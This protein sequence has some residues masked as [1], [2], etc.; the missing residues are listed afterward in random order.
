MGDLG[1]LTALVVSGYGNIDEL[2]TTGPNQ[3][4]QLRDGAVTTYEFDPEEYGFRGAHIS[5]L[6]GDDAPANAA[7]LR[8]ILAGDIQDAKRDVVLLNAGAALM[9]GGL[10]DSLSQGIEMATEIIN[11]GKALDKLDGL[12]AYSQKLAQETVA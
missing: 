11:S 3:V 8:G 12:I 1:S 5:E 2:T 6:L 4:S 9:A 7:I 10:T